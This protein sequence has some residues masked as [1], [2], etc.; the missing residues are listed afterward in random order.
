MYVCKI[1]MIESNDE[2]SRDRQLWLVAICDGIETSHSVG[3]IGQVEPEYV[4]E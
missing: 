1:M 3:L 4:K 2:W